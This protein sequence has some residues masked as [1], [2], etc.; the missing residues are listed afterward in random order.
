MNRLSLPPEDLVLDLE[1]GIRDVP[2]FPKDG[3]TFKDLAGVW[4][5]PGMNQRI[6]EEACTKFQGQPNGGPDCIVGIESRGFIYGMAMAISMRIPFVVF[7]KKGKLPPPTCSVDY[8]LEYGQASLECAVEAFPAGSQV[9]IHDDVLA[10]GGTASAAAQ[11]VR[12]LDAEVWGFSFLLELAFLKG[13][14]EIETKEPNAILHTY[15]TIQ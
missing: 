3:V 13:E 2:N 8:S 15:L 9:L 4:S 5:V 10:T 11:L 6:V 7:R 12:K 14:A 1:R